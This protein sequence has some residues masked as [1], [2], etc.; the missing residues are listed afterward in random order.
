VSSFFVLYLAVLGSVA[1]VGFWNYAKLSGPF[2]VITWLIFFTLISETL[3]RFSFTKPYTYYLYSGYSLTASVSYLIAIALLTVSRF[4]RLII[5]G[6]IFSVIIISFYF[7][8]TPTDLTNFPSN[9]I[10]ASTPFKV[11]AILIY[12][13]DLLQRN[14]LVDLKKSPSFLFTSTLLVYS[15]ISFTHLSLFDYFID[16]RLSPWV[17]IWIHSIATILFYSFLGYIFVLDS[18][19][20]KIKCST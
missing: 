10:L 6:F 2:R 3:T 16:G 17:S 12:F 1:F 15:C 4:R 11:I 9:Y 5:F 13:F 19:R 20:G 18:K 7:L 8:S 14:E